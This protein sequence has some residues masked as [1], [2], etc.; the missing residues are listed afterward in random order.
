[1]TSIKGGQQSPVFGRPVDRELSATQPPMGHLT[2]TFACEDLLGGKF[3]FC[4]SQ[5]HIS[6]E[7]KPFLAP[8]CHWPLNMSYDLDLNK[9]QMSNCWPEASSITYDD[10]SLLVWPTRAP[11]HQFDCFDHGDW[12]LFIY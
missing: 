6:T 3:N 8:K 11:S 2:Q 9:N 12:D 10:P 4:S 5:G 7:A 1:M